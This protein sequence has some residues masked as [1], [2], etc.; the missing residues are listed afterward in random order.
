[1]KVHKGKRS[2]VPVRAVFKWFARFWRQLPAVNCCLKG[3]W[4]G[5]RYIQPSC[6]ISSSTS[7]LGSFSC[8]LTLL[9]P[10]NS[11]NSSGRPECW[12]PPPS[13]SGYYNRHSKI[14]QPT[15]GQFLQH[16]HFQHTMPDS[17][18]FHNYWSCSHLIL[19]VKSFNLSFLIMLG[20]SQQWVS[21]SNLL[22]LLKAIW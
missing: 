10:W 4:E 8:L 13:S 17:Y 12:Q 1:M 14:I 2:R 19:K 16:L 7:S 3:I 18:S 15:A 6:I 22:R 20:V 11:E 9:D 21:G 5:G